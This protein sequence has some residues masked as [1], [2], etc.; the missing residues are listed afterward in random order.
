[1]PAP[2]PLRPSQDSRGPPPATSG[3]ESQGPKALQEAA[4]GGAAAAEVAPTGG[5]AAAAA[6]GAAAVNESGD[7]GLCCSGRLGAAL[8][9]AP[10]T[11]TQQHNNTSSQVAAQSSHSHTL[12]QHSGDGLAFHPPTLPAHLAHMAAQPQLQPQ[13]PSSAAV[14]QHQEQHPQHHQ[15]WTLRSGI[16]P[17]APSTGHQS[18]SVNSFVHIEMAP[19]S[20]TRSH[21]HS[22]SAT[23]AFS[24]PTTGRHTQPHAHAHP[25]S[26]THSQPQSPTNSITA[27]APSQIKPGGSGSVAAASAASAATGDGGPSAI[28]SIAVDAAEPDGAAGGKRA[29]QPRP[30]PQGQAP[31]AAGAG[32]QGAAAATAAAV[33]AASAAATGAE[34]GASD[35]GVAREGS[36]H[37]SVDSQ[38]NKSSLDPQHPSGAQRSDTRHGHHRHGRHAVRRADPLRAYLPAHMRQHVADVEDGGLQGPGHGHD[39]LV[40]GQE[41]PDSAGEEGLGGGKGRRGRSGRSAPR[42]TAWQ[43]WK[44]HHPATLACGGFLLIAAAIVLVIVPPVCTTLGCPPKSEDGSAVA[45]EEQLYTLRLLAR[46]EDAGRSVLSLLPPDLAAAG[47]RSTRL[48]GSGI[49]ALDCKDLWVLRR[50][51]EELGG[52]GLKD[53]VSFVVADFPQAVAADLTGPAR[54]AVLSALLQPGG[55]IVP[56]QAAARYAPSELRDLMSLLPALLA[57]SSSASWADATA[58]L[59][60]LRQLLQAAGLAGAA[61]RAGLTRVLAASGAGGSASIQELLKLLPNGTAP[62]ATAIGSGP[63]LGFGSSTSNSAADGGSAAAALAAL[64][65]RPPLDTLTSV[66]DVAK[67]TQLGG[68]LLSALATSSTDGSSAAAASGSPASSSSGLGHDALVAAARLMSSAD[69]GN[70][71]SGTAAAGGAALLAGS[72]FTPSVT[73][74]GWAVPAGVDAREWYIR[75]AGVDDAWA[76]SRDAD[77]PTVVVA[78]VDGGFDTRHPDLAGALWVNPGE[79]PGNG[80][81]D[82]GNGFVD[83]VNGWDFAGN[84]TGAWRPAPAPPPPPPAAAAYPPPSSSS[85]SSPPPVINITIPWPYSGIVP[86]AS[87]T[88]LRDLASCSGDGNV[89][90]EA[91]DG[92]HGTHVAGVIAAVRRDLAGVSGVA[93]HVRLMLIKVVDGYGASYGSRVAAAL[94][95]AGR[96]GAHVVV[97]SVGPAAPPPLAPLPYQRAANAAAAAMYAAAVRSLRDR[98]VLV[99]APAGDDGMDLDAV[100]AAGM[101]HLPCTL[102]MPPHS[103]SNVLCVGAADA[104]DLR[105]QIAVPGLDP[106]IGSNYGAKSISII[107]PGVDIFSTLPDRSAQVV[108]PVTGGGYGYMS[109]SSAAAPVVAGVAALVVGVIGGGAAASRVTAPRASPP[110]PS[111]PVSAAAMAGPPPTSGQQALAAT[112][113]FFQ[114]ELVRSLL[115]ATSDTAPAG[116]SGGVG[117][118]RRVNAGRAVRAAYALLGNLHLLTPSPAYYSAGGAGASVLFPGLT[119]EYFTALGQRENGSSTDVT[120]VVIDSRP[121]EVSMRVGSDSEPLARLR[122]FRRS[123]PGVLLRLR[124]LLRLPAAGVYRLRLRLAP[125]T[126]PESVQLAV[127]GRRLAFGSADGS[128]RVMAEAPGYYDLELLLLRPTA[129]ANAS[130]A[131]VE[132]VFAT[133]SGSSGGGGARAA[134]YALLPDALLLSAGY[135]PPLPPSYS[136]N[137]DLGG[138][139]SATAPGYHVMWST[140]GASPGD[141]PSA[142]PAPLTP[143]LLSRISSAAAVL[144]GAGAAYVP[145]EGSALVPDLFPGPGDLANLI[146]RTANASGVAPPD[147]NTTGVYGVAV[148]HVRPPSNGQLRLQV[149]CTSCQVYLQGVLLLDAAQAQPVAQGPTPADAAAN[150]PVTHSTGCVAFPGAAASDPGS[151]SGGG[152]SSS[153][154]RIGDLGAVYGLE[155]R[156]EV[157][158]VPRGIVSLRW[159]TCTTGSGSSGS[160][161]TGSTAGLSGSSTGGNSTA[162]LALTSDAGQWGSLAGLLA[163]ATMWAPTAAALPTLPRGLQCDVWLAGRNE[164]PTSVP[165]PARL[166]P[167]ASIRLP[168]RGASAS[169]A[170]AASSNSTAALLAG[171]TAVSASGGACANITAAN[172]CTLS[173]N[174]TVTALLTALMA[175]NGSTSN[176]SSS[177]RPPRPPSPP[178][179]PPP[180]GGSPAY[181]VRCW[182]FWSARGFTGN[183]LA[184]RLPANP[185]RVFLGSQRVYY[186]DPDEPAGANYNRLVQ[187]PDSSGLG[188]GYHQ[189][190]AYEFAGLSGDAVFGLLDGVEQFMSNASLSVD[191]RMVLPL[192]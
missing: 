185:S 141:D 26:R 122:T 97:T 37:G 53:R 143:A 179:P 42:E 100:K 170:G 142:P 38:S 94:E 75:K 84:C 82:D 71:V 16:N 134:Q 54:A 32:A 128:A 146:A 177:P 116:S 168:R 46:S 86:A 4:A 34:G 184:V 30:P 58:A 91:G 12:E 127:G 145:F 126:A 152:G 136:P 85:S 28:V 10:P 33:P 96:M 67:Q 74:A 39:G 36:V 137:L 119:E 174:F 44:R 3:D 87:A 14:R 22:H 182:T 15:H 191:R 31:A 132:L 60:G 65:S 172:N 48:P 56:A 79:I 68:S 154:S 159:S 81:D 117:G 186:N 2:W 24:G 160:S 95:Y 181:Y 162:L 161:S 139:R 57:S 188:P 70:L 45:P 110:P 59:T 69:P 77:L 153:G 83:D 120:A 106:A 21:S 13:S 89:S 130:L 41:H 140:R 8:H 175:A 123:G 129:P 107:A 103:L 150:T 64:L 50:V 93:P 187:L 173:S 102:A 166:A 55:P 7:E 40:D 66:E 72:G 63:G 61:E 113:P 17:V 35:G 19:G 62:G 108:D 99:V 176:N 6:D 135:A 169:A 27:A 49:E 190:L 180:A 73:A 105:V 18:D 9:H 1:M 51:R 151:S 138:P 90:P 156:F 80:V 121:T 25:S 20:P 118:D 47:V 11:T 171:L 155:V 149:T 131:A 88:E 111:P 115:L 76:I 125:G 43:K 104:S 78:V 133:D 178:S 5:T 144:P 183:R 92:G 192:L 167:T 163:S 114:A 164:R 112:G 165:S 124:G 148:A 147:W 109:G 98:G 29:R 157:G 23:S 158:Y 101:E 189:L 52:D